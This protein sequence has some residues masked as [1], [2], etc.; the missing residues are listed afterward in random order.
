MKRRFLGFFSVISLFLIFSSCVIDSDDKCISVS[1]SSDS[2]SSTLEASGET[3]TLRANVSTL[4]D[5]SISKYKWKVLDEDENECYDYAKISYDKDTATLTTCNTTTSAQTVIVKCKVTT[6]SSSVYD[7]G[8]IS[9]I[10]SPATVTAKISG[11]DSISYNGTA[12]LTAS[13]NLSGSSIS[14]T[15]EITSGSDYASLSGTNGESV[16]LTGKNSTSSA[17]AVTIQVTASDGTGSATASKTISVAK[18]GETVTDSLTGVSLSASS[19]SISASG[20]TI[21]TASPSYAGSPTISYTWEITSGSDY[22]RLSG[23]NGESVTLTGTNTETAS[24]SVTVKVTAS[25]GSVSY[26]ASATITVGALSSSSGSS[27]S[28]KISTGITT[29]SLYLDLTNGKVSADNSNW[30]EITTSNTTFNDSLASDTLKVKFTEDD[31]GS[32]T[33]LIKVNAEGY[34]GELTVNISGTMT[35]GGV[36]IQSNASDAVNVILNGAKITSSNY[37]CLEVTKGSAANVTL[38]GANTFTDG[39]SYGTGYGE[40]YS[41]SSSDTYTDDDG[42]PVPCTVTKSAQR[43]GSDSKG[44]LYSK[45]DL[46]ILG[47]GSLSVTQ[48]YKNCIASKDGVLTVDGG[49][50]TLKNY[51]YSS[52]S[53]LSDY[54]KIQSSGTGKNGLFGGKGILV[55]DGTITFYGCGIVST[56]DLRKANA[57]KTDDDDYSSSYVTIAGGTTSVTTWNGKGIAAPVVKISGGTNTITAAGVTGFTSDNKKTGSY[58]DADGVLC[59]S[60]DITFAP[61]GIEGDTS[62]SISGGTTI[63][64]AE[65]DD[66]L[67]AGSSI[68]ISDGFVYVKSKGDGIDSNGTMSVSGGITVVCTYANDN[69]PIDFDSSFKVTGGKILAIGTDSMGETTKVSSSINLVNYSSCSGSANTCFAI[70]NSSGTNI[71]AVKAPYAYSMALYIDSSL[72]GSYTAY[73]NATVSGSEYISGTGFYLPATSASGTSISSM[74]ASTSTSSSSSSGPG[75]NSGGPGNR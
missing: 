33:G 6:N 47:S 45:G 25:D 48:A 21:L 24:Q 67:N 7:S 15:W 11:S 26:Y 44:T 32:S 51:T 62:I 69:S 9:F 27:S 37:P 41:T 18:N 40:E 36:K 56:S 39:R 43:E 34:T 75:G 54:S 16:T 1:I 61:E 53:P 68:S 73:K 74:T 35:S 71:V 66:G 23:T 13:S 12:E 8:E 42:N 19:S 22:A 28:S 5:V 50:L 64:T 20:S 49:T 46:K 4:G 31:S 38:T 72:S 14:Y 59:A 58:Y 17:Q 55:N 63:V 29:S 52:T 3:L 57:F 30:Y 65:Y 2:D 60:T 70:N 10:V